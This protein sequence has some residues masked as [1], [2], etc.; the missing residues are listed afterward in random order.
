MHSMI[1]YDANL[2]ELIQYCLNMKD[3]FQFG[4]KKNNQIESVFF[5][6][7]SQ[8]TYILRFGMHN[9]ASTINN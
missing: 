8:I 9:F 7:T 3:I 5:H 2:M 6:K 4:L 1:I